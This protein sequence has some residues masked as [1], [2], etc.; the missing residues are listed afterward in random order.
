MPRTALITGAS[1]GIGRELAILMARDGYDVILLARGAEALESLASEINSQ[2]GSSARV[3]VKDLSEPSVP[4]EIVAQLRAWGVRLD[5]L[6]NN[7]GFGA[8][9]LFE[10]MDPA[11]LREMIAVNVTSLVHLTRLLLTDLI[12]TRGGI[13]NVASTAAFQPGPWMAVY[14]ATKAMVLS[15]S[16]ALAEEL[17]DRGVTVTALCPGPTHTRFGQRARMNS[18]GAFNSRFVP[19][20]DAASVAR[21][22]YRGFRHGR[23]IVIPGKL[24]RLGVFGVRFL[25]RGLAAR[26]AGRFNRSK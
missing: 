1:S 14:Y 5:V 21:A 7:A 25:P 11:M 12:E 10:E 2:G 22:G 4:G 19:I 18:S 6:V 20:A 8:V 16:A 24:N 17:S 3:L 26:I 15:F 13:L 9:G 23:R